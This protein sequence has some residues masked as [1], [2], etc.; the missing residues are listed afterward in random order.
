MPTPFYITV[1]PTNIPDAWLNF[2]YQV[3]INAIGGTTPYVYSVSAGTLPLG[4]SLDA[5][6]GIISGIPTV[7]G[8]YPITITAT[9]HNGLTGSREYYLQVI[10]AVQPDIVP[11]S[12]VRVAVGGTFLAPTEFTVTARN[13]VTVVLNTAPPDNVEVSVGVYRGANW[14]APGIGEPSNGLPLQ[15]Q[16]TA[17]AKFLTDQ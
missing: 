12:V 11:D 3:D 7:L 10:P 4:L 16:P 15:L 5:D 1:L 9:D 8:N 2:D 14:Y 6:T 17:A 13:P